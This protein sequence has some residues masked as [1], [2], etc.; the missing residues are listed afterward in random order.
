MSIADR[1]ALAREH[2]AYAR[3]ARLEREWLECYHY[4]ARAHALIIGA[5]FALRSRGR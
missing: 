3:L 2:L 4:T 1:L 5:R